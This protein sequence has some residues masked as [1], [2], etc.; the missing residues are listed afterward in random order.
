MLDKKYTGHNAM[1]IEEKLEE[2]GVRLEIPHMISFA[3]TGFNDGS[4]ESN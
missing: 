4:L 3:V 2:I 1:I